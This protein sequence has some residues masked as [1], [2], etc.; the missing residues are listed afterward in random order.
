M[1]KGKGH[2][3]SVTQSQKSHAVTGAKS[4]SPGHTPRKEGYAPSL[5]AGAPENVCGPSPSFCLLF[6]TPARAF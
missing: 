4:V 3:P 1:Q 5:K 2:K 6:L